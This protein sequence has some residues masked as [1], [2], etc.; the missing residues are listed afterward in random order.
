MAFIIGSC[1][2]SFVLDEFRPWL[3]SYLTLHAVLACVIKHSK[4]LDCSMNGIMN[5]KINFVYIIGI[6]KLLLS[7]NA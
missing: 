7:K 5:G 3:A 4:K 1:P 2:L 6:H